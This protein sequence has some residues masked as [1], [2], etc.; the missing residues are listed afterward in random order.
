MMKKL[1]VF[2]KVKKYYFIPVTLAPA[3]LFLAAFVY[4]PA[5]QSLYLSLHK[6]KLFAADEFIG[7][8]HY[9]RIFANSTFLMSFRNTFIYAFFSI[10]GALVL[11][12][13]LA[14][15]LNTKI[16]GKKF[17]RTAF[18]APYIIPR[19][20]HTLLWFWLLD[21]QFGLVNY[22]LG[23]FGISAIP[24]LTSRNWVLSSFVMIDIWKRIGFNMVL[25]L[26]GL[27][28]IPEEL[29]DAGYVDGANAWRR[30][31]H[32]TLPMLRPIT[33]FVIVISFL[34]AMQLFVEPFTMTKGGPGESS[35]TVV[36]ALYQA[37]FRSL[38]IGQAS[39][40]AVVLFAVIFLFTAVVNRVFDT[41]EL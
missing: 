19:S 6:T 11:G 40:M 30:F 35:Y 21:P 36:Y 39:A 16:K 2:D 34:H 23:I 38:D 12:L 22:L 3:F 7:L 24:W 20:A 37:G 18:F 4:Y 26:T 5:V 9:K 25:F 32:I 1:T 15:V 33:L 8:E 28:T 13:F 27:T 14:V 17:F 41:K 10:T 31:V 29:Y